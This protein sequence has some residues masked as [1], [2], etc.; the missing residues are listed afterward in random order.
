MGE[1]IDIHI[2]KRQFLNIGGGHSS[3]NPPKFLICIINN[4]DRNFNTFCNVTV[5]SLTPKV[6]IAWQQNL[7]Y[8]L[9]NNCAWT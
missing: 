8:I 2:H 7:A 1:K 9:T 6:S 5:H 4:G 3:F